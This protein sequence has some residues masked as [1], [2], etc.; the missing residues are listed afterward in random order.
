MRDRLL[1]RPRSSRSR[2]RHTIGITAEPGNRAS[3]AVAERA[4]FTYEG[5]LR[6]WQVIKG[7]RRDT[8]MYSLLRDEASQVS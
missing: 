3:S 7:E 8:A 1:A 4:G 6:S 5:V 2:R